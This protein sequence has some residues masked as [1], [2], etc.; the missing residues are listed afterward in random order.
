[1]EDI[2]GEVVLPTSLRRFLE[3]GNSKFRCDDGDWDVEVEWPLPRFLRDVLPERAVVIG[4]NGAGDYL[5]ITEEEPTGHDRQMPGPRVFVYWHEGPDIA[6]FSDD[7]SALTNP[8]EPVPSQHPPVFYA[9]GTTRVLIGDQV[10]ARDLF[11]R[12]EGRVVYVPGISRRNRDLE[13]GGLAWV[14]IR[15][16]KGT[17]TGIIVDPDSGRLKK[18]VTFLGRGTTPVEEFGPYED[19]D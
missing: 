13:H 2:T 10:S 4:H 16:H 12:R 14:A 11:L 17:M 7:L 3:Q 8:P 1:M 9:D 5:F 15:F 19:F 6:R 18:S